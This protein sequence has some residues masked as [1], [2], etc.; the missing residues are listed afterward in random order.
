MGFHYEQ[1]EQKSKT[2]ANLDGFEDI[3]QGP[4]PKVVMG[5]RYY[6]DFNNHNLA[7]PLYITLLRDPYDMIRNWYQNLI[8][9]GKALEILHNHMEYLECVACPH[10]E[11]YLPKCN[12]LV[13]FTDRDGHGIVLY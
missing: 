2:E 12:M 10:K 9:E 3:I 11:C 7:N 6:I 8:F 5:Q 1:L 4:C 13:I